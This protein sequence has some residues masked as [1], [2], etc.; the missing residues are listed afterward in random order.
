[1]NGAGAC[2]KTVPAPGENMPEE[3]KSST[4]QP[5]AIRDGDTVSRPSSSVLGV[6][7]DAIS[8]DTLMAGIKKLIDEEQPCRITYVNVHCILQYRKD[9]R[10]AQ[11]VDKSDIVYADGQGVV[12]ASR[13]S[14]T[15]L[16]ERVNAGDLFQ[17]FA[18]V[19]A[20]NGYR[21]YLLGGRPEVL[22]SLVL[23]LAEWLPDLEIA[24][25]HHG[26]F[27]PTGE[28]A[29]VEE[30]RYSDADI[31][32]VGMGVPM[33]E[34][35]ID[36]NIEKLGTTIC[37]GVG[38]LFE[39]FSGHRKRCPVWMRRFGLEWTFRLILEP[40]RLW[41]RYLIGNPGFI[42]HLLYDRLKSIGSRPGS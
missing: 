19:C 34:E 42:L 30:I 23:K 27:D 32:L 17:D 40:G 12:W 22:E 16:P 28:P 38:A 14:E 9:L 2:K 3:T 1:M 5:L 13:F 31:L 15:R 20:R 39:Y 7:I 35:F 10:Y 18:N 25:Y 26:Y 21:V 41:K 8:T 4:D 36:R 33:Q 29:V 37:W 6:K 24:G 11:I